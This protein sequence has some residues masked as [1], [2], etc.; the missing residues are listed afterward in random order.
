MRR[1]AE[2]L[3]R[4]ADALEGIRDELRQIRQQMPGSPESREANRRVLEELLAGKARQ[5]DR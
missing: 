3:G 4:I 5:R 1:L 2:V